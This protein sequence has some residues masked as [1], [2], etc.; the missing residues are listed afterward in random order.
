[1]RPYDLRSQL[2]TAL[3]PNVRVEIGYRAQ[4]VRKSYPPDL[5]F[6]P[7]QYFPSITGV[8]TG[9]N[10]A[11]AIFNMIMDGTTAGAFETT[12]DDESHW[13]IGYQIRTN[14]V[15]WASFPNLVSAVV[16]DFE[17]L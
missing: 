12:A 4:G 13:A 16:G 5:D 8:T 11:V 6:P 1:M 3:D 14:T 17:L 15:N 10:V 2:G 7:G 9:T